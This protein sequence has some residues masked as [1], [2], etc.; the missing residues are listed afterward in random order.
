MCGYHAARA[1]LTYLEPRD[2]AGARRR[3]ASTIHPLAPVAGP[4]WGAPEGRSH[5]PRPGET[6]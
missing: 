2:E 6:A 1:A 4:P 5:P 3:T